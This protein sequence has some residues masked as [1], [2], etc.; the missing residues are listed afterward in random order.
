MHDVPLIQGADGSLQHADVRFHPAKQ[1]SVASGEPG[2]AGAEVAI[3]K[4]A[5]LQLVHG[6]N[7]GKQLDDIL[8][9]WAKPL[10]ILGA[11]DDGQMQDVGQPNQQL[12]VADQPFFFMNGDEKPVLDIDYAQYAIFHAQGAARDLSVRETLDASGA[13]ENSVMPAAANFRL[14]AVLGAGVTAGHDYRRN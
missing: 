2:D 10:H 8:I 9:G 6:N 13:H 1:Q 7:P 14:E 11:D 5:K 3:A 4:A 12:C